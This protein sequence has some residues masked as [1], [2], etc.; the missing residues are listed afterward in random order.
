MKASS[1]DLNCTDVHYKTGLMFA[2]GHSHV[3]ALHLAW[4]YMRGKQRAWTYRCTFRGE[5]T[6]HDGSSQTTLTINQ[7]GA[8]SCCV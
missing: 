5:G 3:D 8:L 6:S 4:Q 1:L 7:V 2:A